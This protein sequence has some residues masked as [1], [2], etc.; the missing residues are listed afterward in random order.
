MNLDPQATFDDSLPL[1]V[2]AFR[3]WRSIKTPVMIWLWYLNILYLLALLFLPRTEAVW[4][5]TA[6]LA[7]GPLIVIMIVLQ[8]GLTRLSGLIHLPWVPLV[9][10][11]GLRLFTEQL[12]PQIGPEDDLVCW[13]WLQLIFWSTLTCITLDV[14]DV[15]RWFRGER[16]V[17][18]TH[19]AASLGASKLAPQGT[20]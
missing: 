6:Y 2:V 18:G 16:Y 11:L 15:L 10:Y 9:A 19:A 20:V 8:R 12:G 1:S 7:V 4:A 14:V 17:L 3:S 13:V 5:L